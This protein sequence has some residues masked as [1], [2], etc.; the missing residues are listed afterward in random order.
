MG[1]AHGMAYLHRHK[2]VHRD[3]KTPNILLDE[4]ILPKIADFGLGRF[5]TDCEAVQK[6]TG[7]IGTP[8]WMAP[9]LL[10]GD[11][12][13]GTRRRLCIRNDFV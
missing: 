3:L 7:N 10:V 4:R 13:G 2:I 9:E 11:E 5:V 1:M 8:I 6:M 12:Y